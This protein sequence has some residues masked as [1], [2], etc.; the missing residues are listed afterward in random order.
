[1]SD[2]IEIRQTEWLAIE[3]PGDVQVVE[4][5]VE[6]IELLEIPEQ[7]PAGPPGAAG[8]QGPQGIP[9]L[10][11]ANYVHT[12]AVPDADWTITHGLGRYP[13]VTVVDSA[14]STVLGNVEYL[15]ANQVVVHFNGA[16]GGSAYLN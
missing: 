3:T 16:F 4:L 12:Q 14:G 8:A 2:L 6:M 1:M 15:S 13:S 5:P 10:S 7:G 11:G 9:G